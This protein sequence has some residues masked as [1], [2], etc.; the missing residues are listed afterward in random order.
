M[1][2]K[3]NTVGANNTAVG[4]AADVTANNLSFATTIGSGAVVS[5]SNTVVLGRN[6]DT[7]QV[8][9][10]LN[11]VGNITGTVATAS[12]ALNLGGVAANQFVVTTDP[13]MTDARTPTAGS[14]NYIQNGS[15][16]QASSNFNISGNGTLAGTLTAATVV[17]GQLS[18]GSG[19]RIFG[20]TD[21]FNTFVGDNA[22]V[23]NAPTG[24]SNSF[25]GNTAGYF[26]TTGDE[27][28]FVGTGTGQAN[29]TGSGNTLIGAYAELSVNNLTNAGAIGAHA[30]VSQNNS[31]ILGSINGINGAAAD[32]NVG[33]GT[34]APAYKLHVVG[35]NVRV[36]GNTT[37]IFPRFS[38]NFTGGVADEKRWQNYASPSGLNFSAVNDAE[39][40]ETRWLR[41]NRG[42]GTAITSV[43]FE[44]GFLGVNNLGAAGATA[45]CRN[46]SNQISTCSSSLR[47]KTNIGSFS[48]GLA[49]VNKLRPIS[50]D[51]KDGGMKDI[52]F[53]AEDI[54][55]IDPR[56][57][58]Y[59]SAGEVEGV[60][61]DRLSVAFVNAFKEQQAQI[62]KQQSLLEKQQVLIEQLEKRLEQ[63][64]KKEQR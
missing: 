24:Q 49:F 45:L 1:P 7:V 11:V 44:N 17:T 5:S 23:S 41:V 51:W 9:G 13:R 22:G 50:F 34:T 59:N 18:S 58:T 31:L 25:I 8:P 64:E 4:D 54:A 61:Y 40:S 6:L 27:N 35:E 2:E 53:G 12:N 29:T 28:A 36:E 10:N 19:H 55:K 26:S 48:D 37:S 3:T 43:I 42:T 14:A 63:L 16:P 33:I 39:N 47:Y 15:S 20:V 32:T 38:H 30:F 52:G 46:A 56:F 60:K 57:V 62:K 21:A